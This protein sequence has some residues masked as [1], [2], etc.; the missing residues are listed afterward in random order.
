MMTG[1]F[2][3]TVLD[4]RFSSTAKPSILGSRMS[5]K[6]ISGRSFLAWS[7]PS[8]P[9]LAT[10]TRYPS[11]SSLSLYISA[12][13]GSSSMNRTLTSSSTTSL[14][15]PPY[16]P[17]LCVSPFPPRF[18]CLVYRNPVAFTYGRMW[19]FF[20]RAVEQMVRWPYPT[21]TSR[22]L[23]GG[24]FEWDICEGWCTA[25]WRV[26]SWACSTRRS[27]ESRPGGE[28]RAGSARARACWLT[29]QPIPSPQVGQGAGGDRPRR[30]P[31][32]GQSTLRRKDDGTNG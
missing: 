29:G 25:R 10:V 7:R 3:V 6:T 22:R 31:R 32:T 14:I 16:Y 9:D 5:R 11:S 27:P 21:A 12:T 28:S 15:S 17:I 24:A 18:R 30:Q 2:L 19:D 26:P 4:R 23:V 20:R 8:S 1:I 13:A